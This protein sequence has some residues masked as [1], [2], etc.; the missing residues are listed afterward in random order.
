M[1]TT[2]D[3]GIFDPL[4]IAPMPMLS[5]LRDAVLVRSTKRMPKWKFRV[6][7][8]IV[9]Q[10]QPRPDTR[11]RDNISGLPWFDCAAVIH[12]NADGTMLK[13]AP[14]DSWRMQFR[15]TIRYTGWQFKVDGIGFG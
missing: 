13:D 5:A 15:L 4:P 10:I 7:P 8:D 3:Y 12:D 1:T 9:A 14:R 11:T 2:S 6:A